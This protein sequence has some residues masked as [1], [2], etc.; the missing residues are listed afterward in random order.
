MIPESQ[1]GKVLVSN[2]NKAITYVLTRVMARKF[3]AE[4]DGGGTAC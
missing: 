4:F 2:N 3:V 1:Y